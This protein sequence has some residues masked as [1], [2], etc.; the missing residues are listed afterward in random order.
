MAEQNNEN[1][2]T[3]QL[4]QNLHSQLEGLREENTTAHRDI[5]QYL[6]Q[7]NG[8]IRKLEQWRSY[9]LGGMGVIVL[10][11]ILIVRYVAG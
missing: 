3:L 10:G 2:S 7:Q 4:I 6:Q 1:Q 8:R 9:I 11:L 5:Q